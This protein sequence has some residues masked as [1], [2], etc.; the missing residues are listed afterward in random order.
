MT[1]TRVR[2]AVDEG[3]VADRAPRHERWIAAVLLVLTF[4]FALVAQTL[5]FHSSTTIGGDIEY[6]RGVAFTMSAGAW[7]GEGPVDGM[8][9]YFGGLYPF[10]LGWGSRLL[11]VSF[12]SLVSVVSWPFVLALPLALL[13]LGRRLWPGKLLEPAVLTFIGTVG[14]SLALDDKVMWVNS[15]L[16]SGSNL[17][18]VYPRD[19]TLVLLIVALGIVVGSESRGR[20]VMAGVVAGIAICVHAQIGVYCVGV[21]VAYRLWQAWPERALRR[22]LRDA[23]IIVATVFVVSV[24]WWLPR[25]VI[26]VDTRRLLLKSYP[27]LVGPDIS[28]AGLV[29]A[30]G[31]VGIL[32]VPGVVLALRRHERTDR[33]AAVW[34]LTLAP[35]AIIGGVVGDLGVVTPRRLWFLAALPLVICASI[36]TSAL[37]RRG[38]AMLMLLLVIAVIGMPSLAEA[39]QTRDHVT[40]L[41]AAYPR[42]DPFGSSIWKPT[43]TKLQDDLIDRG[44]LRVIAP[45]NDALFIWEKSGAQ[46]FSFLPSGSVKLGFDPGQ[47]TD[48]SYMERVRMLAAAARTGLPGMCRLAHRT[49]ADLLVLRRDGH[50]LGTYDSRPSARYRVDPSRRTTKTIDRVVAP[51]LRYLDFSATEVLQVASEHELRLDWSSPD[52]RRVDVYQDRFRPVPPVVL[53][54]PDG[55]RIA[56]AIR[57]EG[58]AAVLSFPTPHGIPPGSKLVTNTRG[59][60]RINRIIGYEPVPNLPGPTRGPVV[61]DPAKVC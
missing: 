46:P 53:M 2:T 1:T 49:N 54:L 52:V 36:A 51:G 35:V 3:V 16:P 45:D 29:A 50:L 30:L 58:R 38:P 59:R 7:Q 9:S 25:L 41:W 44:S 57:H 26:V 37:I 8:I 19:V 13:W 61:L 40:E 24:W 33:F 4:V 15:L 56:P 48:Y 32:A 27:G 10:V 14:S 55:V 23:G 5:L 18:P 21:L 43:L 11:G 39:L 47:T 31:A 12:D 17:W 6:H 22:W 42:G 34:L 20:S 28:L 60:S